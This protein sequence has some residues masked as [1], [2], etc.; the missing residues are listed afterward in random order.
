MERP[1]DPTATDIWLGAERSLVQIQSPRLTETAAFAAVSSAGTWM[2]MRDGAHLGSNFLQEGAIEVAPDTGKR[3]GERAPDCGPGGRRFES[4][5]SPLR[6]PRK[7]GVFCFP[8]TGGTQLV[9]PMRYQFLA[10]TR[11][12]RRCR[13]A[14]WVACSLDG[15]VRRREKGPACTTGMVGGVSVTSPFTRKEARDQ[16]AR[17]LLLFVQGRSAGVG[18]RRARSRVTAGVCDVPVVAPSSGISSGG[19]CGTRGTASTGKGA[20]MQAECPQEVPFRTQHPRGVVVN[21]PSAA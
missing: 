10:Q 17:W 14:V 12:G 21:R 5:R 20:R 15:R 19:C 3:S 18:G 4:G 1:G 6:K 2:A 13:S 11:P 16:L 9:V 7:T 8:F